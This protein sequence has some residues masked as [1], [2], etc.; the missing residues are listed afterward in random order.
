MKKSFNVGDMVCIDQSTDVLASAL[1]G[2]ANLALLDDAQVE[3][4]RAGESIHVPLKDI[5][6]VLYKTDVAMVI[7]HVSFTKEPKN[8]RIPSY[9]VYFSKLLTTNG[10]GWCNNSWLRI[11]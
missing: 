8:K 7:A 11:A 3:T 2:T 1:L 5:S 4:L 9:E 10:I 6:P